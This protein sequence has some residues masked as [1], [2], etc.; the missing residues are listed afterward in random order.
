MEAQTCE[1]SRVLHALPTLPVWVFEDPK[2]LISKDSSLTWLCLYNTKELNLILVNS[3]AMWQ[4]LT[5]ILIVLLSSDVAFSGTVVGTASF[6][7][8]APAMPAH[9]TGRYKKACGPEVVND[10]LIIENK[11]LA[12][13]VISLE[14]K[15]LKTKPGEY[16]LDQVGCRYAPHTIA[17]PQGSELK[18]HTSDPINHNIHTYSFDNDPI[19][20]MFTPDQEE[21]TQ[22]MEEP[23]IVKVECDLHSWMAAWIVVTQNSYFAVSGKDGSFTIPDI[24]PGKYQLTAWH[25]ALGSLT[26]DITVG[27]GELKVDFDFSEVATE[28][29]KK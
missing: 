22:E 24:P 27:E 19:N 16:R 14:G 3:L 6:S 15:K 23:E 7:G 8:E 26:R 2:S 10:A 4:I 1:Q 21:Y 13:A 12:N 29:S 9:K 18:I 17:M 11:K 28:A 20:I 25:E 5:P